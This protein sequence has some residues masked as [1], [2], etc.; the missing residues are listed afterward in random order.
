MVA[1]ASTRVAGAG[2]EPVNAGSGSCQ[3]PPRPKAA[4]ARGKSAGVSRGASETNAALQDS[5]KS[6]ANGTWP[7][8][9]CSKLPKTLPS[10]VMLGGHGTVAVGGKPWVSRAYVVTT[11]NVEPG[12][13]S[14]TSALSNAESPG[15]LATARI[16]P[17]PTR[18][19][20]SAAGL[21]TRSSAAS[22]AS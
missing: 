21:P 5:A 19:A 20:T 7:V 14:P 11:L 10:T 12:G 18:T 16:A 4:A 13:Y 8:D 17:V 6:V 2:T 1:A 3:E 22:A 15:R 9:S